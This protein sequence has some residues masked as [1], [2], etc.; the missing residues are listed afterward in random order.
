M[1]YLMV[2]QSVKPE[3]RHLRL[4]DIYS[5]RFSCGLTA[6]S[7]ALAVAMLCSG[8]SG[9]KAPEPPKLK[10]E[11]LMEIYSAMDK[12]DHKS[13]LN[14]VL[15]L[16]E[17]DKNSVFLTE[18]ES[19]E[20]N[21]MY[22]VEA[23]RLLDAGDIDAASSLLDG[24]IKRHGQHDELLEAKA[25][26]ASLA[27]ISALIDSLKRPKSAA[28][29][30]ADAGKMLRLA[31]SFKPAAVFTS[32][33]RA[34]IQEAAEIE[35]FEGW[36]T[37]FDLSSDADILIQSGSPDAALLLAE[38]AVASP[39]YPALKRLLGNIRSAP[40]VRQKIQRR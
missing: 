12:G 35:R 13:A 3:R 25:S 28:S 23:R 15:R 7:L 5:G 36:M 40:G 38:L 30:K 17:I 24:A 29:L 27:E 10:S 34:K 18:L 39:S 4:K 1:P 21:N 20:R 31:D 6:L 32:L 26:I 14:K 8:C 19:I 9:R 37:L 16:R 11:L 22:L 2:S 33:A